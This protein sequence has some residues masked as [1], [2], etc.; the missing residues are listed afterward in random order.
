MLFQKA[1]EW[2]LGLFLAACFVLGGTSQAIFGFK[3]PLYLLSL[4]LIGSVFSMRLKNPLGSLLTFPF[5]IFL[6]FFITHIISLIPLPSTIWS[7]LPGRENIVK[8]FTILEAPLPWLPLS[9]TPE[10]TQLALLNF[11]PAFAIW[12]TVA[13]SASEKELRN[14]FNC[15]LFFSAISVFLG[16]LQLS[17]GNNVFYFYDVSHFGSA[18]GFFSNSNHQAIFLVMALPF[19]LHFGLKT[20]RFNDSEVFKRRAIGL[21]LIVLLFVGIMLT[22]SIAGYI[23]AI[24]ISII[25]LYT[26][27]NVT[28]LNMKPI[29]IIAIILIF[30]VVLDFVY[31]GQFTPELVN[32]I[33]TEHG[34]SRK[35]MFE[36]T[37]NAAKVY[38]PFGSGPGS[39]QG[40]YQLN[41]SHDLLWRKFANQAHNDYLQIFLEFGLL[42]VIII[43]ASITSFFTYFFKSMKN[44]T[45][46]TLTTSPLILV[47]ILAVLLH[48]A[49]DYPMRTIAVASF[50]TFLAACISRKKTSS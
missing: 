49:A 46:N 3:T 38:F 11:L 27:K 26:L 48:S 12:F 34:T 7:I 33:E 15:I 50:A 13:L 21:T 19:A 41:E 36:T 43:L 1:L 20:S 6:T 32:E 18:T 47:S 37:Y 39:F 23:L 30:A 8:G 24:M 31:L 14:T 29:L 10:K 2:R 22:K 44:D 40:I 25:S 4:A 45:K 9:L 42:G 35:V 5:I 16:F 17:I 28:S